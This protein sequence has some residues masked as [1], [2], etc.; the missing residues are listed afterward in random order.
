VKW[1]ILPSVFVL[2]ALSVGG[3]SD[4]QLLRAAVVWFALELLIYQA[5][6]QWNDIAGFE[7][8]Q[9]HP[10]R[11]GR[12]RLP[13][14]SSHARQR[15]AA[16]ASVI[17]LRLLV[18]AGLG[19]AFPGL[20]VGLTN[21]VLIGT[22]FAVA[23]LYEQLKRRGTGWSSEVPPR[24]RPAIIGLWVAV[25][26]GY[27][28]RGVTGL[29][30]TVDLAAHPGLALAATVA[31][32][33]YGIAFVTARWVVEA[34]AFA[35]VEHGKLAWSCRP[36]Q[37]REHLLSLVRWLPDY[38]ASPAVAVATRTWSPLRARTSLSAPWNAATIVSGTCAGLAGLILAGHAQTAL[39]FALSPAFALATV[40]V[41]R[42]PAPAR[43]FVL[44]GTAAAIAGLELLSGVNRSL[45]ALAPWLVAVG[46][47]LW[48]FA[49]N[50]ETMGRA[51]RGFLARAHRA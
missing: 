6:Y 10:D 31:M 3:V 1:W 26:G 16:S 15:K 36:G 11:V 27:A 45:L 14:P 29:A 28:I 25:G 38:A 40:L 4:E 19:L 35:R 9:D 44:L 12:G 22:V 2:S 7:S 46:V 5:R 37:H 32:W 30:L 21:I 23:A 17:G 33:A 47:Q 50:L 51:L 8:D 41:L 43:A 18:A 49:Q 39:A 13:G 42:S 20:R 34:L 24:L 48:F